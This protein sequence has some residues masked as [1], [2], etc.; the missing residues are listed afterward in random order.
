M[1]LKRYRQRVDVQVSIMAAVVTLVACILSMNICYYVTYQNALSGLND[2]V[3]ALYSVLVQEL[4]RESFQGI[5]HAGAMELEAYKENKEKLEYLKNAS[6]VMYLYTVKENSDGDYIYVIDGLAMDDDF[7]YPGDMVEPEILDEVGRALSGEVILPDDIKETEWG[8]IFT[9][10]WPVYDSNRRVIGAVGIEFDASSTYETY[11]NLQVLIGVICFVFC[12]V[13][14]YI[15]RVSFRR[16]SN[17]HFKDVYNTDGPTQLKNR[18]AYEVDAH[19]M[20]VNGSGKGVGIVVVDM[21]KLKLVNDKLGHSVGDIYIKLVADILH[22][23]SNRDM[24]VYR[25]GGDEFAVIYRDTTEEKLKEYAEN[26]S[27]KVENQTVNREIP[28]SIAVGYAL[29]CGTDES[30]VDTFNRAD[31]MMYRQKKEMHSAMV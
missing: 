17:P 30:L 29:Y 12:V 21:N 5:D 18:N 14:S 20:S 22:G 15:A 24:I 28:A 7:R 9:T 25:I 26:C 1:K 13:A 3:T 19:N 2:R 27:E 4:N 10:Y 8:D 6:G 23:C 31:E 16:V 11:Q